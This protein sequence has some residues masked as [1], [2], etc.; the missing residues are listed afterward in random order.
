MDN[1]K[2]KPVN[3]QP[4]SSIV[5][6][7]FI[8]LIAIGLVIGLLMGLWYVGDK[9]INWLATIASK[10]DAVVIVALITGGVSIIGVIFSS[11]VSKFIDYRKNRQEYLAQKREKPYKEFIDMIYK[12]Q[13]NTNNPGSY[14]ESDMIKDIHSF[15]KDLSLWGSKKVVKNWI[16]FR[17][18]GANPDTAYDNMFIIEK[19]INEMRRDLGLKRTRK[20]ELLSFFVN[21]IK[22][23]INK[24]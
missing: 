4:V 19:I 1:E 8:I 12:V 24:N 22:D 21:D 11:V 20:G 16:Q 9:F 23:Y 3:K 17:L 18:N 5:L 10:L 13:Q 7:W 6:A 2:T 15:S 14:T